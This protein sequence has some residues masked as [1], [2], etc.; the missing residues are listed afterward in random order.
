LREQ[1]SCKDHEQTNSKNISHFQKNSKLFFI[2]FSIIN[3]EEKNVL[4]Q[5]SKRPSTN[6]FKKGRKLLK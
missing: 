1:L 5:L 4:T 6:S 3:H 2:G